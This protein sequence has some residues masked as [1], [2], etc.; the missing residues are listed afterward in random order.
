MFL[1]VK[2]LWKDDGWML[3]YGPVELTVPNNYKYFMF[4]E[5]MYG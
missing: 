2:L 3:F 1:V 4:T 5:L